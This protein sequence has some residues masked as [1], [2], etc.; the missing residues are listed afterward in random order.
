MAKYIQKSGKTYKPTKQGKLSSQAPQ[1][2]Y[3]ISKNP[4]KFW[5]DLAK[6]GIDWIKPWKTTY[7][8]KG[9]N[10]EWFKE[11]EL[12][13]CYNA[14]DRHLD[15]PDK[16]AII[17]IPENPKEKKQIITYRKLFEMVNNASSI[18]LKNK[19][20]KGDV[21]AIY[22]PMIPEALAFM[23]ACTRI[24]A[25]H[26]VVFSAYSAEGLRTRIKDGKAKLV[27]TSDYYFRKGKKFNLQKK[28]NEACKGIKI[29]KIILKRKQ[30]GKILINSNKKIKT[31]FIK[32]E[33]MNAEDIAFILYTSGT[34]GAPKGVM[35]AV[36]G[37]T[38]QAYWSCKYIFN[39][40]ENEVMWCTADIGWITGHTYACYGPLL[41]NATTLIYE[42]LPNY[43]KPD[44]Y[45]KIIEENKVNVFYTAPTALRVFALNTKSTKKY[46]LP[47]LKILGSVGEP[48]DEYTWEWFFNNIGKTRCPIVDTYWQ[49]ETGSAVISS[50]PGIGPF[51]PTYAGK[52]FPGINHEVIDQKGKKVKPGEK[53]LLVQ[54]PPFS[55]ALLRG[56]WNNEKRYKKYFKNNQYLAGDN[57]F[58]L[59]NGMIRILGRSDD[60]IKVAGHRMSTAEIENAIESLPEVAETAIVAKPDKI[61]GE[62]PV[63]FIKIKPTS[64]SLKATDIINIV[65]KKIGPIAKPKEV[66][67]VEDIPK[68][69]SGKMM[70]RILKTLLLGEE[71]KNTSTLVNPK[72]V[73]EI[74]GIISSSLSL[75]KTL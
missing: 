4:I 64:K 30:T 15:K 53:G 39:L 36:G 58:K 49:T 66:Y 72:S 73:E 63:A 47:S 74:K 50:L 6:K 5:N 55:P 70:R 67:F 52:S 24:G 8:Q 2:I 1:N 10:F 14:V 3:K 44:R 62:V 29:K 56:V 12:N 22:M 28:A 65:N 26:S 21:I 68:T 34:T 9:V 19:I 32:P 46:S 59:K 13:L 33:P 11:G 69:R 7:K 27:I 57:A 71:V 45:L 17:F 60:I 48:I 37:Y 51:K 18:L 40:Q 43:P 35:H 54:T 20:K 31:P 42:G 25:I 16:P 61:K 23:L 41:N 75:D 38:V